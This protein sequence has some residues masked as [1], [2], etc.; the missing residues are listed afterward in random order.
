ME[1]ITISSHFVKAALYGAAY[2]DLP[3]K[4]LLEMAGIPEEVPNN[5]KARVTATQYTQLIRCLWAALNDELMGLADARHK[6]GTF[7]MA[8]QLLIHCSSLERVFHKGRAFYSLFE[9]PV[10]MQVETE[11][12]QASLVI[13]SE[14]DFHDPYHLLQ[15]SLLVIWHPF[16]LL[17]DQPENHPGCGALQ[18]P[19]ARPC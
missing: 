19:A 10:V 13:K 4:P 6:P 18:L 17:A 9:N 14:A 7:A 8:C 2:R 5:P 11:G 12:E 15:E 3:C 1:K 16:G